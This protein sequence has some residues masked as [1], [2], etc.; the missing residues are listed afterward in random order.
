MLLVMMGVT[1]SNFVTEVNTK[2]FYIVCIMTI[3]LVKEVENVAENNDFRN[4]YCKSLSK[5]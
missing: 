4:V 2:K 5:K 3:A 1:H